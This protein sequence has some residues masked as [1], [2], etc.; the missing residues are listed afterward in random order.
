MLTLHIPNKTVVMSVLILIFALPGCLKQSK[1]KIHKTSVEFFQ[2]KDD[3]AVHVAK[4]QDNECKKL[5]GRNVLSYDVQPFVITVA[6]NTS[7]E[8]LLR[9]P[10]I[11]VPV[12]SPS[13]VALMTQVNPLSFTLPLSYLS[14]V[15]FWPALPPVV[16]GGAWLGY[17]NQ[18]FNKKVLSLGLSE[19]DSVEI[20]PHER[21]SRVVFVHGG[22]WIDDFRMHIFNVHQ[23][24][25][26]PFN[27]VLNK[28]VHERD[29]VVV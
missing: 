16:V 9:V 21:I 26:V 29:A 24:S 23:K 2:E 20:L 12:T 6:N 7:D 25:F 22:Q 15:Y 18:Q 8:L 5:L 19:Q 4:L 3:V 13:S 17:K 28:N 1:K 11:H 14:A 10:S 27:V